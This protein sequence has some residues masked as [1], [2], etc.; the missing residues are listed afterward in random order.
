[1]MRRVGADNHRWGVCRVRFVRVRVDRPARQSE[2][3]AWRPHQTALIGVYSRRDRP[4]GIFI[5]I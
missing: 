1:M 5:Y 3:H 4:Q 2:Q